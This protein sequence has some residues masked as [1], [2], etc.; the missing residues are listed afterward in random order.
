[1]A[2]I[3]AVIHKTYIDLPEEI[4]EYFNKIV[5]QHVK[6]C[7]VGQ[8]IDQINIG[9]SLVQKHATIETSSMDFLDDPKK[10]LEQYL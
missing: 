8:F 1:M 2:T 7:G 3:K 10:G 6:E 5:S 4:Q 9:V